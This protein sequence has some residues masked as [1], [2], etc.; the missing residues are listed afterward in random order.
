MVKT[1]VPTLALVNFGLLRRAF[2]S[3]FLG[4]G[5]TGRLPGLVLLEGTLFQVAVLVSSWKR[6]IT[7]WASNFDTPNDV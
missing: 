7:I 1:V 5:R 3:C 4:L 2:P 6:K